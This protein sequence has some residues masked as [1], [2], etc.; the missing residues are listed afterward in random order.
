MFVLCPNKMENQSKRPP[1]DSNHID[2]LLEEFYNLRE[3]IQRKSFSPEEANRNCSDKRSS[4]SLQLSDIVEWLRPGDAV[5]EWKNHLIKVYVRNTIDSYFHGNPRPRPPPANNNKRKDVEDV[6]MNKTEDR[7]ASGANIRQSRILRGKVERFERPV[8]EKK[9]RNQI[10]RKKV[11]N[12]AKQPSESSNM[13]K[14]KAQE[15]KVVKEKKPIGTKNKLPANRPDKR[16]DAD[17]KR[18]IG[19]ASKEDKLWKDIFS[20]NNFNVDEIREF[21]HLH[22]ME[23]QEEDIYHRP[24]SPLIAPD[25]TITPRKYLQQEV[26]N[27]LPKGGGEVSPISQFNIDKFLAKIKSPDSMPERRQFMSPDP[28]EASSSFTYP[29]RA[30]PLSNWNSEDENGEKFVTPQK[31]L[32]EIKKS[33]LDIQSPSPSSSNSTICRVLDNCFDTYNNG[34]SPPPPFVYG[35]GQDDRFTSSCCSSYSDWNK[36]PSSTVSDFSGIS[37]LDCKKELLIDKNRQTE[38][39]YFIHQDDKDHSV[40]PSWSPFLSS[41]SE[42]SSKDLQRQ[43]LE[44]DPKFKRVIEDI[45]RESLER[46]M[47]NYQ[48]QCQEPPSNRSYPRKLDFEPPQ[49]EKREIVSYKPTCENSFIQRRV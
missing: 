14:L 23:V 41:R 10:T 35:Y 40:Y 9:I 3:D 38:R 48:D 17:Q 24:I 30:S 16:P 46:T 49:E 12:C 13:N 1:L 25:V 22:R 6:K 33:L 15:P 2:D 20:R 34:Q 26:P 43:K 42:G 8:P 29:I 27:F 37:A 4:D 5:P 31:R 47:C 45:R 11:S 18:T 39:A 19:E 36:R 28:S 21:N 7:P 44:A 32:Q